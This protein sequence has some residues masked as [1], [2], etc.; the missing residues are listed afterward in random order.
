MGPVKENKRRPNLS[1]LVPGIVRKPAREEREGNTNSDRMCEEV[2]NMITKYDHLE[3]NANSMT[4]GAGSTCDMISLPLAKYSAIA[5]VRISLGLVEQTVREI[6][7]NK[8][9]KL[10]SSLIGTRMSTAKY[11]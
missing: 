2:N 11:E 7:Q 8:G 5:I 4:S 10:D 6:N 9:I 3:F 1:S